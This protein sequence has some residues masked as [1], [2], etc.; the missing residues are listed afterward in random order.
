MTGSKP[1]IGVVCVAYRRPGPLSVLVQCFLNQSATNWKLEIIHDGPDADVERAVRPYL[2]EHA[3]R[4]SLTF[5]EQRHDDFGHSLRGQALARIE[6]DYVLLTNDD[7]YYVPCFVEAINHVIAEVDP[8][9]VIYDMIHSHN[10]PGGR[11]LPPYSFFETA[12]SRRNI[13]I[14]AAVV[15]TSLAKAAGFRDKTH[16]GDATYFEDVARAKGGQLKVCKL[17]QVLFVHN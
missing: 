13:D 8:D 3:D 9:V 1:Q 5:S 14:G 17:P 11:P 4:V 2:L 15:R 16:D 10:R 6:S 7:N 12:Y